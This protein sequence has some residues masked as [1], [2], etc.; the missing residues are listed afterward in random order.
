M[1][2]PYPLS[3]KMR[4]DKVIKCSKQAHD[5]GLEYVWIDTCCID[6]T[7]SVELSE[8]INSMFRWYQ[9]AAVCY[10]YLFDVHTGLPASDMDSRL[11][12][13]RWLTRGLTLQEL[14]AEDLRV[15][16][17]SAWA[18]IGLSSKE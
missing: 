14:I 2:N 5:A 1:A 12:E 8:A 10:V 11:L 18:R 7:N 9:E 3:K 6:K 16:F 15:F 4:Y 13:G 17:N